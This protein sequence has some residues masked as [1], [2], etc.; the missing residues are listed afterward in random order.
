MGRYN[1]QFLQ[2]ALDDIDE[3][4]RYISMGWVGLN[5][6]GIRYCSEQ[7]KDMKK[8]LEIAIIVYPKNI[9]NVN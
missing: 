1:I 2:S 9:Y 7:N 3:I 6:T 5:W 4:I 8:D